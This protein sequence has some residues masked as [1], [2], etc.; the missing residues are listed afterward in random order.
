MSHTFRASS[1]RAHRLSTAALLTAVFFAAPV[2]AQNRQPGFFDGVELSGLVDTYHSYNFNR[3]AKPCTVMGGI[4]IFNC[5]RDAD[6]AHNDL[7]LNVAELAIEKKP[8]AASRVGFRVDADFGPGA[9]IAAA[10]DTSTATKY[11][12]QAYVSY[13]AGS[14]DSGVQIDAGKFLT[15]AGTELADTKDNWNYSHGLLFDYAMPAYHAGVRAVWR[16]TPSVTLT[17]ALINGWNNV[18]DNNSGKSVA[19]SVSAKITDDLTISTTYIGGP[20][21]TDD[22]EGW[23]HLSDTTLAWRLDA[24]TQIAVNYDAGRDRNRSQAWQG[25][26]GYIRRQL[27]GWLAVA[28]RYEVLTDRDGF[29]TGISQT[30]HEVTLTAELVRRAGF[31]MRVEYRSDFTSQEFFLKNT[32]ETVNHQQTLT[33]SLVYALSAKIR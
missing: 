10:L 14:P 2:A 27:T 9:D 1:S 33:V 6:V 12:Q 32:S 26:A 28:P 18:V 19:V 5:L 30:I 20:E 17:G 11:L 7:R 22:N 8:A 21:A 4:E 31:L 29:A 23:R 15:M 3:P 16:L 13:L 24:A 25:A